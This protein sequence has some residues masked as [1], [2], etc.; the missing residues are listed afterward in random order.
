MSIFARITQQYKSIGVCDFSLPDFCVLTGKNGGGKSHILE[1][2]SL[3]ITSQPANY[4]S[5]RISSVTKNNTANCQQIK[6]IRFG[7]LNPNI[8]EKCDPSEINQFIREVFNNNQQYGNFQQ[9]MP[10]YE[11]VSYVQKEINVPR[12]KDISEESL[13]KYFDVKFMGYDDILAGKFALIFKNYARIKDVN[14]SNRLK[15]EHGYP[16]VTSGDLLSDDDFIEKYGIPP[17]DLV[18]EIFERV[19]TWIPGGTHNEVGG[20]TSRAV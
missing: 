16:V 20:S 18:N 1:A 2:I 13:R 9:G 19:N 7:Q 11:F 8:T 10:Y 14:I 4:N 12:P 15:R 5:Q 17:W 6:M 3:P